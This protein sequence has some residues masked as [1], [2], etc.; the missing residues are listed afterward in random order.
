MQITSAK[1]FKRVY[2]IK[3]DHNV[4]FVHVPKCGGTSVHEFL[5]AAVPARSNPP[6]TE[7]LSSFCI[8]SL[9]KHTKAFEIR[10]AI[11]HELW[12]S[13]HS[14]VVVRNP[15][16]LMVSSYCWWLEKAPHFTTLRER[17]AEVASLGSFPR[18]LDSH[19]GQDCINECEGD[20]LD[21]F[22]DAS[23]NDIVSFVGRF[24]TLEDDLLRFC[25]LAQLVPTKAM[26]R[27]NESSRTHYRDYYD[28]KTRRMI[29]FRFAR[30]IERFGY[31]Y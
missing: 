7:R 31:A 17:A 29:E 27:L 23:R 30:I 21:W 19:Y 2:P 16:D 26:C 4:V 24:E 10:R 14:F 9:H 11:G 12:E 22:T 8:P 20:P 18:F 15:W 13:I 3:P 6:R 25:Q 1:S 5:E 28:C